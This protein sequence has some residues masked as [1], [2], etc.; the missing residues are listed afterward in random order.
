MK[1]LKKQAIAAVFAFAAVVT[2]SAPVFAQDAGVLYGAHRVYGRHPNQVLP[3][4]RA[5]NDYAA[6]GA[7]YDYAAPGPYY[8][9][10]GPGAYSDYAAPGPYYDYAAPGGYYDYVPPSDLGPA[11]NAPTG[12]YECPP[13]C[14]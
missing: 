7:Y 11:S 8:D 14:W 1:S 12:L 3:R 10:A 9:Y 5:Y 2:G 6:P 13:K 4:A